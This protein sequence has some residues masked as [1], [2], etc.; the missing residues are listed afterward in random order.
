MTTIATSMLAEQAQR[1]LGAHDPNAE[2]T[3]D[4]GGGFIVRTGLAEAEVQ[5]LLLAAS[6]PAAARTLPSRS[7]CCGG[8]CGA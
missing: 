1:A 7:D 6:L 5:R 8:C 2:V 3:L 4:A